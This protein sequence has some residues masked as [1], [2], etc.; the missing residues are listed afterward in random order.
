M[1]QS[2]KEV[3]VGILLV[4]LLFGA[5]LEIAHFL[6]SPSANVGGTAATVN[7]IVDPVTNSSV[8]VS[9]STSTLVLASNVG[10]VYAAIVNN[11]ANSIW[12]SLGAAAVANKGILLNANG[13]SYEINPNNMYVGNIY[14]IASST[15]S[16]VTIV[17]K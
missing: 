8:D 14:A 17:E 1:K 2:Y 13:G 7:R 10:R 9:A 3:I 6:Q 4:V 5:S 11:S 12:I 16:T 15:T